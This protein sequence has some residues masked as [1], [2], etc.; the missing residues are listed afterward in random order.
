MKDELKKA[1]ID[2]EIF[3]T[4]KEI[5]R[6]AVKEAIQHLKKDV[7]DG[8]TREYEDINEEDIRD[9]SEEIVDYITE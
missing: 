5:V 7:G 4:T 2:G 8:Y 3:V 1:L 9:I 6:E